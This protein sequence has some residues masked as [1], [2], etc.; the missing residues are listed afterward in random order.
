ML[1]IFVRTKFNNIFA[2]TA[3]TLSALVALVS[4]GIAATSATAVSVTG[5]DVVESNSEYLF[6]FSGGEINSLTLDLSDGSTV[7]LF[8]NQSQFTFGTRNQGWW[9][10]FANYVNDNQNDNYFVGDLSNNGS[11]ILNNFFTFDISNI[12]EVLTATL[13]LERNIG[14]S[15][16]GRRT[17]TYLL[18]DVSTDAATLN[19]NTGFNNEIWTDLKS[20]ENYGNFDVTV[21]GNEFEIL[22]FS[23]NSN[24]IDDINIAI[25]ENQ[26]FFSIGGTLA[27]VPIPEP[28]TLFGTGTALGFGALF[29]RRLSKK[30]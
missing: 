7:K 23:L 1:D 4:I 26:Q 5:I 14:Q 10:G 28:L 9:S 21:S 19:N 18:F 15:S 13:N 27:S 11:M 25:L 17:Q 8:T 12:S 29:K 24:A 22:N 30:L 16:L 6:G 20:G 2:L 3:P